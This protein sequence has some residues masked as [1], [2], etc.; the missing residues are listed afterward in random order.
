MLKTIGIDFSVTNSELV[1][2]DNTVYEFGDSKVHTAKIGDKTA[3]SKSKNLVKPFL[4]KFQFSIQGSE[5]GFF[6]FK[7]IQTFTN[8]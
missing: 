3:K 1:G 4:A 6:T 2:M 5:L 7:V 8:L